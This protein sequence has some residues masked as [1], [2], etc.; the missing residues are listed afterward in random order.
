MHIEM[1][2][3]ASNWGC[4]KRKNPLKPNQA[5]PFTEEKSVRPIGQATSVPM[6]IE[7]RTAIWLMKPRNTRVITTISSTT[8]PASAMC[9]MWP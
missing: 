9:D 1:I 6:T 4:P 5:S 8:R 3:A 2:A 7:S